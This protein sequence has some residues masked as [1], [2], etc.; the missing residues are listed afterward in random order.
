M[1]VRLIVV[2]ARL[3][4]L[5]EILQQLDRLRALSPGA[6]LDHEF[7]KVRVSRKNL[8]ARLLL[9]PQTTPA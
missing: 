4:H 8:P 5:G 9:Q 2:L 1:T 3:A 6:R 7:V